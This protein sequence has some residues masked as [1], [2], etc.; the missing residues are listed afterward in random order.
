MRSAGCRDADLAQQPQRLVAR[1]APADPAVRAQHLGDLVADRVRRDPAPCSGSGTRPRSRPRAG[2]GTRAPAA[3]AGRAR[4]SDNEPSTRAESGSRPRIVWPSV[5]LPDP[6]SPTIPSTSPRCTRQRRAADRGEV[7]VAH[8]QVADLEQRAHRTR[9]FPRGSS[10][11][12]RPSPIR[13]NVSTS[14]RDRH[15]R[16]GD[17]PGRARH[18]VAPL[19]E[20]HAQRRRRRLD[21]EPD[22]AQRG[23]Q[24]HGDAE[25]DRGLDDHRPDAVG[26]HVAQ[27]ARGGATRRALAPP[28][29]TAGSPSPSSRPASRAPAP[30]CRRRRSRS[31]ARPAR[32]RGSPSR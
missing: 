13:L 18:E 27:D 10:Q 2:A 22:E 3:C 26:Q 17:D 29:R 14:T 31:S 7:A 5:V 24:Q 15:A 11:A 21:A 6:D 19:G 30:G 16:D 20:H 8:G 12:C 28:R 9:A 32:C 1:L 25:Q 4:R 23:L